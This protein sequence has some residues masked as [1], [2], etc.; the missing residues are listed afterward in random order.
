MQLRIFNEQEKNFFSGQIYNLLKEY[1]NDFIPPLS[2]RSST[3][4]TKFNESNFSGDVKL[5]FEQMI[6]QNVLGIFEQ[7]EFI[8]FISYRENYIS[9]EIDDTNL[10]N[11]YVSTI[12]IKKESRGR[13]I[14]T[15]A[16]EKLTKNL[17]KKHSVFTRTWSTNFSHIKVLDK[18][19][20]ECFLIIKD[21]R[22]QGIDTVYYRKTNKKST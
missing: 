1:D 14:I 8:G 15:K 9:K 19:G 20:F 6:K 16:Y 10:P 4:Q 7:N 22:G 3:T 11:I 17:F 21:D 5:Y 18:N 12:L 13:G 2:K